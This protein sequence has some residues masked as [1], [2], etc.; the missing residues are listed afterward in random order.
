MVP[1]EFPRLARQPLSLRGA[2]S[3]LSVC[4][5]SKEGI[6]ISVKIASGFQTQTWTFQSQTTEPLGAFSLSLLLSSVSL[7]S[8]FLFFFCCRS[9]CFWKI[10]QIDIQSTH[11]DIIYHACCCSMRN[12]LP[13][14]WNDHWCLVQAVSWQQRLLHHGGVVMIQ[15]HFG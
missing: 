4:L 5:G 13:G 8:T 6:T 7:I 14:P 3:L 12:F 2:Q 1:V 10:Q 9:S 11:W 15:S